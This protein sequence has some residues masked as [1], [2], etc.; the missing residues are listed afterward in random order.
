MG[1]FSAGA[2]AQLPFWGREREA[3][4]PFDTVPRLGAA[5]FLCSCNCSHPTSPP[6]PRAARPRPSPTPRPPHRKG[7]SAQRLHPGDAR[8]RVRRQQVGALCGVQAEGCGARLRGALHGHR[9]HAHTLCQTDHLAV[10]AARAPSAPSRAR[11][12]VVEELEPRDA[13]GAGRVEHR[14]GLPP[15][16]GRQRAEGS[17]AGTRQVPAARARRGRK[18][19]TRAQTGKEGPA[20]AHF[21][22]VA[23]RRRAKFPKEDAALS[24]QDQRR[25]T[26]RPADASPE[27]VQNI[28]AGPSQ[29]LWL[30]ALRSIPLP[31]SSLLGSVAHP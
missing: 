29:D 7:V 1:G 25:R 22:S 2:R 9:G 11:P 10:Q 15:S 3:V 4:I 20:Q 13:V 8:R 31:T 18:D 26:R 5:Q 24:P 23:S 27:C 16:L 17:W 30:P 28:S 6:A 12:L 19:A 14:P 21:R